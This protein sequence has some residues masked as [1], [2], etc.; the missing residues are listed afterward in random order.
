MGRE[1]PGP[2]G[3]MCRPTWQVCAGGGQWGSREDRG[4]P[5]GGSIQGSPQLLLRLLQEPRLPLGPN[6][7][8]ASW[9]PTLSS[10][11]LLDQ[12]SGHKGTKKGWRGSPG[13]ETGP[14]SRARWEP[15][16]IP[17]QRQ[18]TAE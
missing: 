11:C 7:H 14:G 2:T 15:G 1:R 12:V 18:P 9:Q 4:S 10:P 8:P 17:A 5:L 13:R 6:V 3:G 16:R